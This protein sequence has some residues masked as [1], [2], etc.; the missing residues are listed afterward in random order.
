MGI[1]GRTK[2]E[3]ETDA[4]LTALVGRRPRPLA[5]G[6]GGDGQVVGL[7]D[8]LAYRADGDWRQEFWHEVERGSWDPATRQ[9]RWTNVA[10][11]AHEVELITPGLLPDL[12]NER[13]TASIACLQVVDLTGTGTAVITARRDLGEP[14]APLIWRTSPGKGVR[15][16]QVAGDPL[17][18]REL[19]RLRA[20][21]DL[22]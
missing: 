13:V 10:G 15:A 3:P 16:G 7:V 2:L 4:A 18:V 6:R 8:R 9:L 12:F 1:F 21:Y 20:E 11:D 19:E 22:G 17:V 14:T 5:I